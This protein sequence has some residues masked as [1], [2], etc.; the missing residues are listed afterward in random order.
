MQFVVSLAVSVT[1]GCCLTP[2]VLAETV[3]T[4]NGEPITSQQLENVV[5]PQLAALEERV[6]QTRQAALAKLI[7]NVLL[8]QDARRHFVS[9]DEYLRKHVESVSVPDAEVDRAYEA[10]RDQF[11]GVLAAEAKYRVRR[12]LEDNARAAALRRVLDGLRQTAQV[13][14]T[15]TANAV[16]ALEAASH[17][18]PAA[19]SA[20]ARVT[21]IEFSDFECPY[22]RSAQPLIRAVVKR[23]PAQ[24]RHV[25]KHF[26]LDQH[27]HAMLAARAAVCAERQ[28]RFWPV[29]DTIF[30]AQEVSEALIRKAASGAGLR[31][32][33][34][35]ECLKSEET[36]GHV[37]KDMLVGRTAGVTGTPAFFVN[38]RL[39][40]PSALESAVEA[41]LGG[42]K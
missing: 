37:R 10:S 18:G 40:A 6:R 28:D 14:N 27:A 4:V 39:V 30:A 26:P 25:F 7:D 42:G 34:F 12:T 31:M 20:D 15:L 24:V 35:N 2:P 41:I 9:V 16:A 29:H 17:E 19:G 32:P 36:E 23:W 8:E 1:L 22:C 33:E 11:P 38:G 3:A 21:I 13:T 5:R